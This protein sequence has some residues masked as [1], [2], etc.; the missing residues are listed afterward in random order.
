MIHETT[1]AL[2]LPCETSTA[3]REFSYDTRIPAEVAHQRRIFLIIF[4]HCI[5]GRISRRFIVAHLE[6][7]CRTAARKYAVRRTDGKSRRG[8]PTLFFA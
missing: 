1:P 8:E 2:L 6:T 7:I 4:F 3:N 5:T